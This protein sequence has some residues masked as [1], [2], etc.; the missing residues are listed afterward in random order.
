M[1]PG[2]LGASARSAAKAVVVARGRRRRAASCGAE[3]RREADVGDAQLAPSAAAPRP[4]ARP[5]AS[6]RPRRAADGS[7]GRSRAGPDGLEDGGGEGAELA[8]ARARAWASKARVMS[9]SAASRSSATERSPGWATTRSSAARPARAS[10]AGSG[11]AVR[12]GQGVL[13][14]PRAQRRWRRRR[15]GGRASRAQRGHPPLPPGRASRETSAGRG[16]ARRGQL[17]PGRPAPAEAKCGPPAA[18]P[19]AQRR[20]PVDQVAR[21]AARADQI[22]GQRHVNRAA[23][24]AAEEHQHR[25]PLA[26]AEPVGDLPH[27]GPVVRWRCRRSSRCTPLDLRACRPR[28][29]PPPPDRSASASRASSRCRSS[30]SCSTR[31]TRCSGCALSASA[32]WAS[33]CSSSRTARS[34]P[35]PGHRLDPPHAGRHAA[36]AGEPEGADLAGRADVGAAAELDRGS[37][38]HHAHQVAVLLGEERHRAERQRVGIGHL[39]RDRPASLASTS[40]FTSCS[41]AC[42]V[43]ASIGPVVREV[44]PQPVGLH[45]RALLPHVGAQVLPERVVH[46]VRGAVVPLDV[47]PPRRVHRRAH[48]RRA[49]TSRRSVPLTTVPLA[50]FRTASTGSDQPGPATPPTSL[51]WPPDSA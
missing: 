49:R 4:T 30:S 40:S 44:E 15:C 2:Q 5:C 45:Q 51:T 43:S 46:Q 20:D 28:C 31:R 26:L 1:Q 13:P 14:H 22:V 37:H 11:S 24:G 48:R 8:R 12:H 32:T 42:S 9:A 3:M 41:M 6:R 21:L 17:A 7:G 34:A 29:A 39:A 16:R 50:S 18:L 10:A 25:V 38:L 35:V 33:R 36:L 47:V 23:A 27:L 19:A